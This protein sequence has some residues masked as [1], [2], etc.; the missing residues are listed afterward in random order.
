MDEKR[1]HVINTICNASRDWKNNAPYHH[2]FNNITDQIIG[3]R[4]LKPNQTVDNSLTCVYNGVA[5]PL[6][7]LLPLYRLATFLENPVSES[8]YRHLLGC[9]KLRPDTESK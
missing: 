1:Q 5:V 2:G 8:E 7:Q 3:G 9:P 4:K 6:S